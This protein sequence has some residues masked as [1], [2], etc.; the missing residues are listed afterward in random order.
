L[1]V[2]PNP[3]AEVANVKISSNVNGIA[4][5]VVTNALGQVVNSM[6]VELTSGTTQNV[7]LQ[8]ENLVSGIYHVQVLGAN[9]QVLANTT[10]VK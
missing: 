10:F 8:A 3:V 1:N 6:N 7:A 5:L 9:R 2:A 4:T